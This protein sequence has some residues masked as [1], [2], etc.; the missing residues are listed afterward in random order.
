MKGHIP[1]FSTKYLSD[2]PSLFFHKFFFAKLN[3]LILNE[4][5]HLRNVTAG[6]K[7]FFGCLFFFHLL[8]DPFAGEIRQQKE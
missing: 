4:L 8:P 6:H 5:L 3:R 2:L 7:Q 1:T